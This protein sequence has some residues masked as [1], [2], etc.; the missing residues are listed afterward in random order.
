MLKIDC[1]F[2]PW[3]KPPHLLV[4]LTLYSPIKP[5]VFFKKQVCYVEFIKESKYQIKNRGQL[6]K[7]GV[8]SKYIG[9]YRGFS[10]IF[11]H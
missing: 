10:V 7:K 3:W 6:A 11:H 9:Q 1:A 5:H 2:C 8:M 4:R